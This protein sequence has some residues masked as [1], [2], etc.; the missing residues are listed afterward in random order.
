MFSSRDLPF[1]GDYNWISLAERADGTVVG[2]M[3]WTDNRNVVP[4]PTPRDPGARRVQRRLRR[5][6]NA[7][8]TSAPP[9]T[10]ATLPGIPLARSD[11]P[12]TGDNCGNAGGLDQD[13]FGTSVTFD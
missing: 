3:S 12:F 5:R 7:A 9:T 1:H 6:S 13:I 4:A 8:S 2:Y 11:A 10:P